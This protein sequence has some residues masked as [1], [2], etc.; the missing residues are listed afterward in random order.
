MHIDSPKG[1]KADPKQYKALLD[2][3]QKQANVDEAYLAR[4]SQLTAADQSRAIMVFTVFTIIFVSAQQDARCQSADTAQASSVLLYLAIRHERPRVERRLHR[5]HTAHHRSPHGLNLNISHCDNTSA[6]LQQVHAQ[7][8]R[9]GLQIC[10]ARAMDGREIT[11]NRT[12]Y[13]LGDCI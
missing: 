7:N 11:A 2:M 5:S 12:R 6:S 9:V 10:T 4:Q 1:M 3:K 8:A 13:E